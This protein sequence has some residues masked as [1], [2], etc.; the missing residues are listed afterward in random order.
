ME[1]GD[2]TFE[3]LFAGVLLEESVVLHWAVEVVDHE[4]QNGLNLFFSVSSVVC[5]SDI[6][7]GSVLI[8][9]RGQR[10]D[11]PIHHFRG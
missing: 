11:L 4:Q 8:H 10:I 7:L 1:G 3:E 9:S 6:L 2:P 5:E